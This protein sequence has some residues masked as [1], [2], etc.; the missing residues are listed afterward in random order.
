MPFAAG[1]YF[2]INKPENFARPPVLLIHGAGGTHLNWPPQVR[3]LVGQRIFAIDL[4]GH[5]KS[6]GAGRQL[7]SDYAADII[8]FMD[9]LRIPSAVMLG[10]S[11][12]SGICLE[13]ALEYQG[14]VLGLS[15]L[16]A[17]PQL[18]VSPDLLRAASKTESF[19]SAVEMVTNYSYGPNADGRL[20]DLGQLRMAETRP[21]VFYGDL[22]ACDS[23][24]VSN[25][26]EEISLPVLIVAGERDKMTPLRFSQ[27]LNQHIAGSR[28]HILPM[29]GHMLMLEQ[30]D[31]VASL[32]N[33]FLKEFPDR[34]TA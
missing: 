5:G 16:G 6:S 15:L 17:S 24:D 4:T 28:L 1:L 20:K 25:R 30:P 9:E 2:F 18:H 14:R 12:G 34:L 3:R 32:L 10:H 8:A 26:L 22:L 21:S 29:A 7:I 13:L 27:F 31:A 33:E 23:F 19:H 11:L